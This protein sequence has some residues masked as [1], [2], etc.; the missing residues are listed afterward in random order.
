MKN[1]FEFREDYVAIFC[2]GYGN[3]HETLVSRDDFELVASIPG[4][5]TVVRRGN[6]FY[7]VTR[8]R[9]G[10]YSYKSLYMHRMVLE[11]NQGD[12]DHI[13][14]NGLDNR[15]ENLRIVTRSEN[16]RNRSGLQPNNRSGA[17]C[18]FWAEHAK[19]WRVQVK[20][21]GRRYNIGYFENFDEAVT[22][23]DVFCI[24]FDMGEIRL[25]EK[26]ARRAKLQSGV[27]GVTWHEGK[28]KWQVRKTVA[29]GRRVHLG[30]F[31]TLNEAVR[32]LFD[33]NEK[34]WW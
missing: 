26:R 16:L 27:P 29:P 4:T 15:R 19:R 10:R 31:K 13:N 32:A 9:Q 21:N 33:S 1:A 23:R 17:A 5:W 6:I 30:D 18:V 34:Q 3:L 24:Q 11:T 20:R 12:I 25:P 28:R 22:A 8:V 7:A 2:Y 14:H